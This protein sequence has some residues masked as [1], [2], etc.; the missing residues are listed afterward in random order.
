[1]DA[2][3]TNDK[4]WINPH[5]HIWI[6]NVTMEYY[7][8]GKPPSLSISSSIHPIYPSLVD[9]HVGYFYNLAIVDNAPINIGMRVPL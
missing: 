2:P 3:I 9:G 4:T 8:Y 7:M 6:N 5:D 1:M